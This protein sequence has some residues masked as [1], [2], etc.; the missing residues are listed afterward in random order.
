MSAGAFPGPVC[1]GFGGTEPTVTDM[2]LILGYLNSKFYMEGR[3]SLDVES[4]RSVFLA[5]VA[6]PMGMDIMEAACSLCKLT[7]SLLYDM[8][9]KMTVEKG[10]DPREYV[11]FSYGGTA[12]MHMGAVSQELGMQKMI[13]PYA[14]SVQGA[15]GLVSA[16]VVHEDQ[17]TS[18][19]NY[20]V[21]LDKVND[22]FKCLTE[23]MTA[24]LQDEGFEKEDIVIE[25]SID[26]RYRRQVHL[27]TTPVEMSGELKEKDLE[28]TCDTFE[29]LY[30]QRYGNESA[31][32]EAGMEM[33][34]FRVRGIGKLGKPKMREEEMTGTEPEVAFVETRKIYCH[35]TGEIKEARGYD[36]EKLLPGDTV[37]GPS[38]IWTPITTIVVN[39]GHRAKLD[40]HRNV[41]LT[42]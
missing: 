18:P 33:V 17:T 27:V 19:M 42:W 26:M 10:L 2:D 1:Y 41:V 6:D 35:N 39:P 12:G 21:E 36:V 32:R 34:I 15:Y 4:A 40:Q 11:L 37:E 38:I 8:L 7:N 13:I 16:D 30:T 23:K 14:A 20:P 31:Y 3:A 5:K 22:I 28:Q 25:R 9:H 29:K 24:Q